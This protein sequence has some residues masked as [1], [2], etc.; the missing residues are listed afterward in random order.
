MD[1]KKYYVDQVPRSPITSAAFTSNSLS[2]VL[3]LGNVL[4]LLAFMAAICCWTP[5]R[6]VAIY[7]L[8][9]VALADFGHIYA[10][11][12]ALGPMFWHVSQWND[13]TWGNI[14]ASAFLN[15]NRWAT[16]LG[17]FGRVG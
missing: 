15:I 4:L 17:L 1:P 9:A 6:E 14:G 10:A 13:L 11:Y 8:I 5:H 2:L 3:Q 7:Y 12:S 16:V